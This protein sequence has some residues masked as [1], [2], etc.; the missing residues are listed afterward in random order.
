MLSRRFDRLF[1]RYCAQNLVVMLP[2]RPLQSGGHVVGEVAY[3]ARLGNRLE[4]AGQICADVQQV[5]LRCGDDLVT[6]VPRPAHA[7]EEPR[8]FTLNLPGWPAV[9]FA[10]G[11]EPRVS[12]GQT[13]ADA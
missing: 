5:S 1:D 11:V 12:S 2:G 8:H 3:I 9:C 13:A 10:A 4:V 6:T 7:G